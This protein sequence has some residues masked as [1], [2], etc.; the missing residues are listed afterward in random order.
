MAFFSS[1]H[2]SPLVFGRSESSGS[3]ESRMAD[4]RA[5]EFW[6]ATSS[7]EQSVELAAR[8]KSSIS[9][10]GDQ[11]AM[12]TSPRLAPSRV[13]ISVSLSVVASRTSFCLCTGRQRTGTSMSHAPITPLMRRIASSA[14]TFFGSQP[15]RIAPT[16]TSSERTASSPPPQFSCGGPS[17]RAARL[18][19]AAHVCGL[20]PLQKKL[21]RSEFSSSCRGNTWVIVSPIVRKRASTAGVKAAR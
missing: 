7:V 5:S 2:F 17:P 12:S 13:K 18:R 20:Q 3:T 9:C 10:L 14:D 11:A 6:R 21:S 1:T 19:T 15:A 16:A 4:L 8:V